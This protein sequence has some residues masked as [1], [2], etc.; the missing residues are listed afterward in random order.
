M[1]PWL[2]AMSVAESRKREKYA[3]ERLR[4][5]PLKLRRES[6]DVCECGHLKQHH[7]DKRCFYFGCNCMEYKQQ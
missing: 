2:N 5:S 1:L 4:L 7:T 6:E 3:R